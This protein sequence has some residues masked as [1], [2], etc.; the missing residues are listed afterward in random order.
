MKVQS[1]GFRVEISKDSNVPLTKDEA[2]AL[3]VF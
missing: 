3:D 1:K 2:A